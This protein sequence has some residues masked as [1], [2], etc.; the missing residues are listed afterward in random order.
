MA[1]C[2]AASVDIT[3]KIVVGRREKTGLRRGADMCLF[4]PN[5]FTPAKRLSLAP[6]KRGRGLRRGL[7][8]GRIAHLL[9]KKHFTAF[10][11]LFVDRPFPCWQGTGALFN[12]F[13]GRH[14][15]F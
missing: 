11:N 9:G 12:E 6:A 2:S 8:R 10:A 4:Y 3:V 13:V 15:R 5:S 7:G 14:G 1:P